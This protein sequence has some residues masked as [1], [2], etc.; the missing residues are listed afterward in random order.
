MTLPAELLAIPQTVL[1]AALALHRQNNIDLIYSPFGT[2]VAPNGSVPLWRCGNGE[3]EFDNLE[4]RNQYA[5][6][7]IYLQVIPLN[8][9]N[10]LFKAAHEL[11]RKEIGHPDSAAGR[12]LGLASQ[13]VNVLLEAAKGLKTKQHHALDVFAV[14]HL[15][16]AALPHL[17]QI[18]AN[19]LVEV[20]N[21]QH[22]STKRDMAG[23][24]IFNAIEKRLR[25][26]MQ[27]AWEI[28]CIA[29][30]NMSEA[31][32]NLYSAALQS[33][34]HT[35]QQSLALA[36]ARED[37]DSISP[38]I[39]T[40]A[41][42]TLGV[43]IH[44]HQL[45]GNE[46]E[47]CIAV[48]TSKT[49]AAST[50]TRQAAIR[51][52]AYASLKDKRLMSELVRLATEH[53][54]Y[55]LGVIANFLF[56]NQ[57]RLP[58]SSLHF[59]T[60]LDSL[61]YLL[62]SQQNAIENFDWVLHNLYAM[63]ENRP[64]V[65]D[66]LNRWV[67]HHGG[68]NPHDKA[69]IELFDQTIMQIANEKLELQALITR[70][71]VAPE[72]QLAVACSGLISFLDIRG[73][74]SPEF[75]SEVLNTFTSQDFKFLA[76]R[77]LGYVISEEPL[78]SL[79]FSLLATS[80]A[81]ERSFGWVYSLLTDEV[82]RDYAHATMEILR[83]RQETAISPEKELLVKVHDILLRRS[84]AMNDL[85]RLQE[86]RPPMRLRRAITLNRSREMAQAMEE[87]NEKSITRLISTE[88][89]IK[90]GRGWFAVADNNV[91]P[92]HHFQSFS[93]SV[94]LPKRSLTDPVGYAIAGLHY[95][96]A[97]REDE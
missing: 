89:P 64:W 10:E 26:E 23:G 85:P 97:K 53:E 18:T 45:N 63:P 25:T 81:P 7:A 94:S 61:V 54:D 62:P 28:S 38:L 66:C 8:S 27:L 44:T 30:G 36:Q 11:W 22:E 1:D 65:L 32:Q 43:T 77:L 96:M 16:E 39:V 49:I 13:R 3:I 2:E 59:K 29:K 83:V 67:I 31:M 40:A 19:E 12:L 58:T 34:M 91:G 41:L 87:S 46:L 42:W 76:R 5:A 55:A 78:L 20:V 9:I 37:A 74:K 4:A 17:S 52:V 88:I 90:A 6:L 51:A 92:T 71:L 24:L 56:M 84:T 47:K 69:L 14:L 73:M 48:L 75:S 21:A 86:L 80:K 68:S 35:D 93:H 60:L 82:G 72:K 33:L 70:W 79:T 15:L 95:R 50:E 57:E